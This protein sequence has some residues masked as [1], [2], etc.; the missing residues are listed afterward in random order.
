[1]RKW[2]NHTDY[3][4][5]IKCISPVLHG[6][7]IKGTEDVQNS[8]KLMEQMCINRTSP[9]RVWMFTVFFLQALSQTVTLS[10]LSCYAATRPNNRTSICYLFEI[11]GPGRGCWSLLGSAW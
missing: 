11:G 6:P 10:T 9:R 4:L 3:M 2:L 5:G 8:D 7:K 1:M